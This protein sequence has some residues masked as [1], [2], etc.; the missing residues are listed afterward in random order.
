MPIFLPKG[1]SKYQWPAYDARDRPGGGQGEDSFSFLV[2]ALSRRDNAP[3]QDPVRFHGVRRAG[4]DSPAATSPARKF[5]R[6]TIGKRERE[7]ASTREPPFLRSSV[8][9]EVLPC[10]GHHAAAPWRE[11]PWR[12]RHVSLRLHGRCCRGVG[13]GRR[14]RRRPLVNIEHRVNIE[15]LFHI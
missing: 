12:P 9:L 3:C 8:R 5:M 2:E 13:A 14:W 4:F 7:R 15:S 1:L 11:A 10:V 6:M